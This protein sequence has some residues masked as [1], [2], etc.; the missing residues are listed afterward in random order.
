MI[1]NYHSSKTL[2]RQTSRLFVELNERG[3]TTFSLRDVEQITKLRGSS[4]RSL[5][6]K[7]EKRG[8]ITRLRPGLY[9][10]VP[11]ELGRAT[12]YIGDPYVIAKELCGSYG[13]FLSHASAMELLRMVTQPQL[14]IYVSTSVRKP[15]RTIHGYEYRFVT[16]KPYHFFGLTEVW[17]TKQQAI[18]VSDR[19]R[20]ILDGLRQ[21]EY[22]GGIPEVAR[23]LWMSRSELKL[24]RLLDY[25]HR[26]RSGALT[27]RL[28]FLLEIYKVAPPVKLERLR[29]E[30]T[31]TYDRLDP[32]LPK[33]GRFEARWRLQLNIDKSELEAIPHT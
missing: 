11:F 23:A 19:E 4:A 8:L 14:I 5:I 15:P 10:L 12:E 20:T 24:D 17:I 9:T 7:A 13:Y 6:F 2:G 27:R 22:A 28:G 1:K 33:S 31:A 3:K 18:K 29:R 16:V 30:L 32:S 25:A 26:L 21:P